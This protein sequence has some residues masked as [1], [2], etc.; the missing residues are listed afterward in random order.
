MREVRPHLRSPKYGELTQG[1]VFS[2]A[3]ASRYD[4]C[5]VLG[6]TI[7]AR[8]DVA[9]RK[10]PVLNYLPIVSLKDWLRRDGLD[11]LVETEL[12]EQV[13]KLRGMLRQGG[14]SE[15]L[16]DSVP[17]QE[18]A[19]V[20]FPL[21]A[22]NKVQKTSAGKFREHLTLIEEFR[23]VVANPDHNRIF[24]WLREN[25]A[26][27]I[28]DLVKRLSRH[29]VLGHYFLESLDFEVNDAEGHVCL[30]REVST[31]PRAVAEQLGRGLDRARYDELCVQEQHRSGLLIRPDE[32]AMPIIEIGSPTIEHVLQSFSHLFGRIGVADP[33]E[34]VIGGIIKKCLSAQGEV[35]K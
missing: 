33:V 14:V 2:C 28:E 25:R 6:L 30:L 18:I 11:I 17:L 23:A 29:Q 13:G 9:Q 32:L 35:V 5:E 15:L 4:E 3:S 7:T 34:D 22:G 31:V 10:Y 19:E 26:K 21:T 1:T 16:I 24:Q 8:C 20:H 12:S 27:Q